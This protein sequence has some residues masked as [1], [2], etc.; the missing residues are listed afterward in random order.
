MNYQ[1]TNPQ[2]LLREPL[3]RAE[4]L[5]KPLPP[6]PHANSVCLPTWSDVV[7]YEEADPRVISRLQTGYPRFFIHPLTE[8]LFAQAAQRFA[9]PDEF[10]HVYPSPTTARRCVEWVERWS[11]QMGRIAA[12]TEEG[13]WVTCF[14]RDAAEAAKKYWRHTGEGVSSRL[15]EAWL[16]GAGKPD[17]DEA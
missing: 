9:G 7:A 14:P 8:R 6:S 16:Q 17:A 11:G 4:D 15:A 2:T 5:G 12:W 13:P 10:C 1:E 3:W